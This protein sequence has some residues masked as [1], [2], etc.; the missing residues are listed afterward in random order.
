MTTAFPTLLKIPK[1]LF[2][3]EMGITAIMA[4]ATTTIIIMANITQDQVASLKMDLS[5]LF[6]IL[7]ITV[8]STSIKKQ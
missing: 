2:L 7:R 4:I 5:N 3:D 6:A 1:V 8:V